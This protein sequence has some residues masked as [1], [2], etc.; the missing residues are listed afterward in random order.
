MEFSGAI[1]CPGYVTS[2]HTAPDIQWIGDWLGPRTGLKT[3]MEG[4]R[5]RERRKPVMSSHCWCYCVCHSLSYCKFKLLKSQSSHITS[6][7]LHNMSN[8]L[9]TNSFAFPDCTSCNTSSKQFVKFSQSLQSE[10]EP[11]ITQYSY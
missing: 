11:H 10:P 9:L 6:I 7:H 4:G 3:V 8:Y 1:S 5:E 2:W